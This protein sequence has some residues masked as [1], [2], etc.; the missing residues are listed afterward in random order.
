MNEYICKDCGS[1]MVL[2]VAMDTPLIMKNVSTYSHHGKSFKVVCEHE[3]EPNIIDKYHILIYENGKNVLV[4]F[5]LKEANTECENY[6]KM[7]GPDA[8]EYLV[9]KCGQTLR[10]RISS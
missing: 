3:N 4:C 1:G 6:I 10:W 8:G 7:Y 5:K 9:C 2:Y